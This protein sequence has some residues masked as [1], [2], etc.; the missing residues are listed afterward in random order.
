MSKNDSKKRNNFRKVDQNL[1][2]NRILVILGTHTRI[3]NEKFQ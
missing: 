3:S 1:D 2:K